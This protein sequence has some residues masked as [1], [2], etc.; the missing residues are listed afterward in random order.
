MSQDH[1]TVRPLRGRQDL[2]L[3]RSIP[4]VLNKELE[5]DLD[6]GRRRF[7]WLW[8]AMRANR[9]AGRVGWWTRSAGDPPL[10]LDFLDVS[11]VDDGVRLVETAM[12]AVLPAGST[13]P[14]YIRFLPP[15]WASDPAL[16]RDVDV[17][18]TVLERVGARPLVEY[19]CACSGTRAAPCRSP[20]AG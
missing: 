16:V 8:V 1:S 15:D 2:D 17:R 19:A 12:R 3:F 20:A 14:D 4:Y 11:D 7:D 5:G 6:A 13:P 10:V 9:L 18:R